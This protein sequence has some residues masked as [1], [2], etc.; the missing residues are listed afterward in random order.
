[1]G[2]FD[3]LMKKTGLTLGGGIITW[4]NIGKD[5]CDH[6]YL[7]NITFVCYLAFEISKSL[8]FVSKMQHNV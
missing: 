2:T 8:L 1:M 5:F 4:R 7:P 6:L 3:G